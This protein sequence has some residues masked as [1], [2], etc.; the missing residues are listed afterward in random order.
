MAL[1]RKTRVR[2]QSKMGLIE[3]G[4]RGLSFV[5]AVGISRALEISLDDLAAEVPPIE[6]EVCGTCANEPPPGFTCNS[7]R[8]KGERDE[9]RS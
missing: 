9:D 5:D 6:L 4:R 1:A 7:C 2:V 8:T 3:Q